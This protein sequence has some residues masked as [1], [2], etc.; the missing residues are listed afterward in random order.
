MSTIVAL[1]YVEPDEL[2][3]V[4][5]FGDILITGKDTELTN[6]E[7]V[8]SRLETYNRRGKK[9]EVCFHAEQ[10]FLRRTCH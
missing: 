3:V 1:E 2:W 6:L 9:R 8:R 5:Y 10:R 4:C 7:E